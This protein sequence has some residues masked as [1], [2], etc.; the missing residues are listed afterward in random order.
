MMPLAD[1]LAWFID[2]LA[3]LAGAVVVALFGSGLIGRM[4]GRE[5]M[6][7]RAARIAGWSV[8]AALIVAPTVVH[9]IR[10]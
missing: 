4:T 1:M 7:R 8:G 9:L 10:H 5:W 6:T 3:R 2:S